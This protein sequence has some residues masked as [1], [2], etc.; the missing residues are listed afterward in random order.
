MPGNIVRET[1][2]EA[3]SAKDA[4]K[5]SPVLFQCRRP[6]STVQLSTKTIAQIRKE[7]KTLWRHPYDLWE[8]DRG[9]VGK[10]VIICMTISLVFPSALLAY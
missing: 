1:V 8:F 6:L 7:V 9:A 10:R 4:A 2:N 3:A 5:A